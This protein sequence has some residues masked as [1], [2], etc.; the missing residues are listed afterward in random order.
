MKQTSYPLV[1]ICAHSKIFWMT[2]SPRGVTADA[3]AGVPEVFV[4]FAVRLLRLELLLDL[5]AVVVEEFL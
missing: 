1:L 2:L 5:K 4:N 3:T